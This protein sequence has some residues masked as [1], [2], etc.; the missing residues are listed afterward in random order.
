MSA[1]FY[2][3]LTAK[4]IFR[5]IFVGVLGCVFCFSFFYAYILSGIE[6]RSLNQ[7]FYY[8]IS[9]ETYTQAGA[10]QVCNEGGAGYLLDDESG[11]YI[12]Y[13]VY[14]NRETAEQIVEDVN[15]QFGVEML[16]KSSPTLYFKT[17]EQKDKANLVVGALNA[18]CGCMQV[19]DGEIARLEK[20]ATQESSKRILNNLLRQFS[21][22]GKTHA[23]VYPA[24]AQE[25]FWV[26]KELETIL[27]G[28]VYVKDLRFLLCG[29]TDSYLF[30][31][32]EF[33]L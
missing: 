4:N 6:A 30:L 18:Y 12:A 1:D 10:Y 8:L 5:I 3:Q 33:S 16:V 25:C 19:L 23:E 24:F 7:S 14:L 22:L 17:K 26:E 21:Y 28:T 29:L 20:G 9:Y 32:S 2:F 15:Q 11:Q 31:A 13:T 27:Q